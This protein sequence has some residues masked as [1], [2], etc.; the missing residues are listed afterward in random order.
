ML[1]C[2]CYEST[3]F[4][5]H[6]LPVTYTSCQ[7]NC[8]IYSLHHKLIISQ[9]I[10]KKNWNKTTLWKLY[11]STTICPIIANRLEQPPCLVRHKCLFLTHFKPL[12]LI[13]CDSRCI[14]DRLRPLR[15]PHNS[16]C[17]NV[18]VLDATFCNSD[19]SGSLPP[20]PYVIRLMSPCGFIAPMLQCCKDMIA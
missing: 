16:S 1:L 6:Q 20:W 10:F 12:R 7:N 13:T 14:V 18:G 3:E 8:P 11:L 5:T 17:I 15:E 4:R 19:E 9:T 2:C